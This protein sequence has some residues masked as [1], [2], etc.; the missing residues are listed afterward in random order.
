M[1]V[2]D[3]GDHVGEIGVRVD[4]VEFAGL[5]QRCDDRP[6]LAAAIRPGEQR[7][8]SVQR[9]GSNAALHHIGINLDEAVV[10]EA[11]EAVPALLRIADRLGEL[12]LLADQGE[13]GAQPG[14]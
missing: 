10:E 1:V 2:D 8:L 4:A 14:F 9:D 13:L 11:G 5:D 12:G 3:L 7:I 6:M